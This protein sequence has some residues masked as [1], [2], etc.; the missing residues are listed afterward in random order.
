MTG[1]KTS[2]WSISTRGP[3][4]VGGK[5]TLQSAYYCN[6]AKRI[7]LNSEAGLLEATKKLTR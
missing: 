4:E 7:P 5:L 1:E 2:V 6:E 3:G